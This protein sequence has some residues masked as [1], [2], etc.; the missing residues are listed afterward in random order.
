MQQPG[1]FALGGGVQ[2]P[3]A[4][5]LTRGSETSAGLARGISLHFLLPCF[6]LEEAAR[7]RVIETGVTPGSERE[8]LE[9]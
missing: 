3:P 9:S 6:C 1:T 7:I 5:S 4:P 8:G 2:G